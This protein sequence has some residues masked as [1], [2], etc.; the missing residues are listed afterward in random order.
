M[1]ISELIQR[2][3]FGKIFENTFSSFISN[4]TGRAHSVKWA[5]KK[6]NSKATESTQT[7]YCNP[8]INSIFVVG[9]NPDVFSSISGEYANNPIKP[10]RSS[11]QRVYL[12]FAKHRITARFFSSFKVYISPPIEDAKNKLIIGGN[13]KLRLIDLAKKEVYV[14]LK[15][16]FDQKYLH[17]ELFIRQKFPHL[18]IPKLKTIANNQLWYSEEYISGSSPDRLGKNEGRRALDQAI[19]NLHT[20]L[21]DTRSTTNFTVYVEQLVEKIN[22]NIDKIQ[23]INT[24]AKSEIL[25]L[26]KKIVSYLNK[27]SDQI[28]DLAYCHGDF[29]QGNI[30]C[31][32]DEKWILDWEYSGMKQ[33]K[34][35]L[36]VLLLKSRIPNGFPDRFK[37]FFDEKIDSNDLKIVKSW[38]G[39]GFDT[40]ENREGDLFLF[41]LEELSFHLDENTNRPSYGKSKGLIAFSHALATIIAEQKL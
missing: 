8:L 33:I 31:K 39:K 5:G 40:N 24:N 28:I 15:D 29:Q 6:S 38:P 13:N 11:L 1:K 25:V 26:V 23:A 22:K 20:I 18:P 37:K 34:Y 16:G 2:E 14:I 19:Q 41:L 27:H 36:F 12:F 17:R 21:N 10:W 9:V 7:W 3:P 4:L 35:D 32:E 30:L